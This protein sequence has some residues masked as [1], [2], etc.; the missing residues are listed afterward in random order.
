MSCA[1]YNGIREITFVEGMKVTDVCS[2]KIKHSELA[3]RTY[4][5]T[6]VSNLRHNLITTLLRPVF[7]DEQ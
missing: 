5:I 1:K 7:Q 2:Q 6:C 4:G 3:C